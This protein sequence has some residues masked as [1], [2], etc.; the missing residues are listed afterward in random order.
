MYIKRSVFQT[1]LYIPRTVCYTSE[2]LLISRGVSSPSHRVVSLRQA[3]AVGSMPVGRCLGYPVRSGPV[4]VHNVPVRC[5]VLKVMKHENPQ[6]R[7]Y[8]GT[9]VMPNANDK[10]LFI[11]AL[12]H[13][14]PSPLVSCVMQMSKGCKICSLNI[15]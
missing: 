5:T 4:S 3:D 7:K 10:I 1:H 6:S 13:S 2:Y 9:H 11:G 12:S 8:I 15:K 14:I